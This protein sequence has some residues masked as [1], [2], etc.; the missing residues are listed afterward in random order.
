MSDIQPKIHEKYVEFITDKAL[1]PN[2]LILSRDDMNELKRET[3]YIYEY[4]KGEMIY[5]GMRVIEASVPS[6]DIIVAFE[7]V[8]KEALKLGMNALGNGVSFYKS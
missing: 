6:M 1:N 8:K 4:M 3:A 7:I 5:L 2:V